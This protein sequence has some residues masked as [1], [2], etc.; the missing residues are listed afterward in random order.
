MLSYVLG[1]EDLLAS[2]TNHCMSIEHKTEETILTENSIAMI[3]VEYNKNMENVMKK[4]SLV[5]NMDRILSVA[6]CG[7]VVMNID[8]F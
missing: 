1:G 5:V 6:I 7:I 3:V 2:V 8:T 4:F